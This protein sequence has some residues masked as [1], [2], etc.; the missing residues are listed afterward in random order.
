LSGAAGS[1]CWCSTR[2]LHCPFCRRY[3]SELQEKLPQFEALGVKPVAISS[4]TRERAEESV[5]EW[6]LNRLP[7]TW[8]LPIAQARGWGLY[9]SS[10]VR[11]TD[12]PLFNEPGFVLVRPDMTLQYIAVSDRPWGR[13]RTTSSRTTYPRAGN[14]NTDWRVTDVARIQGSTGHR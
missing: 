2:G 12:P 1:A 11:P 3:L 7:V 14:L 4:D 5:A 6:G 10:Q 9:I 13:P 8:G